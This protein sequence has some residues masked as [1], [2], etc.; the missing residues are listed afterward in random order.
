MLMIGAG[1][2]IRSLW[3]LEQVNPGFQAS[4]VVKAEYQLPASRY[5]RNFSVFPRWPATFQFNAEL[6]QRLGGLPG[7]TGV[8][9]ASNHP[10]DAGFQSSIQVI[11]REPEA[12]NWPEPA[13]RLVGAGYFET[14]AVP[15]SEG[16]R[17]QESDDVNAPPVVVINEAARRTFFANQPP[18][19][20]QIG[21]W[22]ASRTVVGVVGNEKFRGLDAE[23]P[24][25]IYIPA[26]QVPSASGNYTVM[27][28][29]AADAA[30][31]MP[32]LRSVFRQMDPA[33]PLFGVESLDQ[34]IS[35]SV[36]QRRF[37]MLILGVFAAVALFLAI[38]GVHGVLSYS[39]AQRTRELGIRIALG[40]NDS[41]I[42]KLVLGQGASLVGGG[43]LLGLIGALAL[44]RVI[45]TLLYGI[46]PGDPLTFAGVALA[47]GAVGLV[48]SY[49]PARRA[50][51]VDPAV[52]LRNE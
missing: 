51:R 45:G 33:L 44:T 50:M 34:T 5:P 20:Q 27:V 12:E 42:R 30:T 1:L 2:L 29:S 28:R 47:L 14:L 11:G 24:P 31:L 46:K 41:S 18:L 21:L 49:L 36:G 9:V 48:A 22:G 17:L 52:A 32:T 19:G 3:Q 35:H 38:V 23:T 10:L 16:R 39:V 40:A 8:A 43:V 26:G 6:K 15:L 13:I 7:V 25:G 4:G 37:T